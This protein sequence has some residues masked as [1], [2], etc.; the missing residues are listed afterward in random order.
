MGDTNNDSD[1]SGCHGGVVRAPQ[2][3]VVLECDR[4]LAGGA[5]YGLDAV[6]VVTIGRGVSRSATRRVERGLRTLDLRLPGRSVSAAHARLVRVGSSWAVEDVGSTNGTLVNDT[7]V[8]RAVL[9]A[10]DVFEVGRTLMRVNPSLAM[11]AGAPGDS[12]VR[13][14]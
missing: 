4:P 14:A 3:V 6:D 1:A 2:L 7:R 13:G 8:A 9:G 10:E 11:P 5:R 12:E